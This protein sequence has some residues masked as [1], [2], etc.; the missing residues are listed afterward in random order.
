MVSCKI[1]IR[2]LACQHT[3]AHF[4]LLE[5]ADSSFIGIWVVRRKSLRAWSLWS[6]TSERSVGWDTK[7]L[8]ASII[9]ANT[10]EKIGIPA[11]SITVLTDHVGP[12]L[13]LHVLRLPLAIVISRPSV[14][15]LMQ[16]YFILINDACKTSNSVCSVEWGVWIQALGLVSVFAPVCSDRFARLRTE[17]S[18]SISWGRPLQLLV[19]GSAHIQR[20]F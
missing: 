12:L 16:Q 6:Q 13:V 18:L 10:V 1:A 8:H 20:R 3:L 9:S 14:L 15:Q 7:S 17:Q 5:V 2:C 19:S 11:K 4:T